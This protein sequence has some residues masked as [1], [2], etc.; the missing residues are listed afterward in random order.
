MPELPARTRLRANQNIQ[1]AFSLAKNEETGKRNSSGLRDLD[2]RSTLVEKISRNDLAWTEI[3]EFWK[4]FG[5]FPRGRSPLAG[6]AP[7]RGSFFSASPQCHIS[8]CK[9]PLPAVSHWTSPSP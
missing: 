4:K 5:R 8:S 3:R 1:D 2:Q 9:M 7:P 6:A